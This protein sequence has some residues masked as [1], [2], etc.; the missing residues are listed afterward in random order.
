[1]LEKNIGYI[2]AEKGVLKPGDHV[3]IKKYDAVITDKVFI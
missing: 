3:R 1:V 2:L